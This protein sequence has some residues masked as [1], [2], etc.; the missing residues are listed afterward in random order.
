M[1]QHTKLSVPEPPRPLSNTF[2]AQGVTVSS[3]VLILGAG[4]IGCMCV[5]AAKA[6]GATS[7]MVTDLEEARLEVAKK[8]GASAVVQVLCP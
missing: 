8:C 5:L 4:P 7:I 1:I 3:K 6:F 2:L